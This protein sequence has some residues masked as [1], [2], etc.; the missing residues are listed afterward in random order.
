M[1]ALSKLLLVGAGGVA[2]YVYGTRRRAAARVRPGSIDEA[3]DSSDVGQEREPGFIPD[4]PD[5]DPADPVQALDELQELHLEDLHVDAMSGVDAE[6][7]L[8]VASVESSLEEDALE[9]LTEDARQAPADTTLDAIER[10]AHD[11]GDLYGLHTPPAV[12]RTHAEDRDTF[13]LGA[14]WLE[15]LETSAAEYGAEPERELDIVDDED[16]YDPP[17]A[18]DNRDKPVAD[19]GSGGPAGI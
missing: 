16:V 9:A 3:F 7:E 11:V 2:A 13:N 18:S 8:M 15:A 12:D 4:S 14:N 10:G 17:H 5:I 19:R 1:R 6:N